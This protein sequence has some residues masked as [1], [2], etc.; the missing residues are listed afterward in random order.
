MFKRALAVI[1]TTAFICFSTGNHALSEEIQEFEIP[2]VIDTPLD[3]APDDPDM[4]PVAD[5]E[6]KPST[7]RLEDNAAYLEEDSEILLSAQRNL[8]TLG[9]LKG[10]ADGI[11]GPMTEAALRSFQ[12]ASGLSSTGHLD[13]ETLSLLDQLVIDTASTIEFQ[14]RLIDLGYLRGTADGKWGPRSTAAMKSFQELNNLSVTGTID[15]ASRAVLFSDAVSALPGGLSVGSRG[16]E[17][18]ILQKKLIQYGFLAGN[19]DGAY[20]QQTSKAVKAFQE[21]LN[22]QGRSITADGDGSPV[23]L[24]YLYLPDFSTYVSKVSLGSTGSEVKRVE[25]RLANLGYMD[26]TPDEEFDAYAAR[27]LELFQR[28]TSLP[29][30]GIADRVTSELL[31]SAGAP[32]T[33]RCALHEITKGDNGL[34]VTYV[35]KALYAGGMVAIMPGGRYGSDVETALERLYE[36]A[37]ITAPSKAALFADATHLSTEAVTVLLDGLLEPH[38]AANEAEITRIQRRLH[39]LYYLGRYEIDGKLGDSTTSAI[40]QFQSTNGLPET[41]EVDP[42]TLLRL[43]SD[44]AIA[45]RLPYRVEVSIN[46]QTVTVYEW[47]DTGEYVQVHQFT[48]STGL[49]NSTPRGIFLDGYPAN[50]WHHF[51]KFD[52]WAQYS[53]EIEGNIMFHSVLYS[54]KDTSTL[55][56]GSVYALGSPASHGCIRLSVKS[57]QWLFNHC[58]RGS[59]VIVIY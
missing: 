59:L 7:E 46:A 55:R 34:V 31:F 45:K 25:T 56:E 39:A 40:R 53:F 21:H 42:E 12:D 24:Y 33:D 11:Y 10:I 58:K 26:A 35:E 19:A 36:Y 13:P 16:D 30:T 1:L 54:E 52:C 9:Y 51:K 4:V 20:G 3:P 17:V 49:G 14:Q 48:C 23:T 27:A 22:A 2:A 32:S 43:F 18:V 8:I 57:A 29:N 28:Q 47:M 44:D 37:Q 41:G 50:R 38:G 15:D 5:T 6:A